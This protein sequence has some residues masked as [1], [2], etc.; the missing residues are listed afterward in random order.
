MHEIWFILK[1]ELN[2]QKKKKVPINLDI[3]KF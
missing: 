1:V 3:M 2:K